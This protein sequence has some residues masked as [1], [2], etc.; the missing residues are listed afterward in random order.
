MSDVLIWVS[1][2]ADA[3]IPAGHMP[4]LE[5]AWTYVIRGELHSALERI[6]ELRMRSDLTPYESDHLTA[7]RLLILALA[8]RAAGHGEARKVLADAD[9]SAAA[10]EA[11]AMAVLSTERW[12]AGEMSSALALNR[13]AV[14]SAASL[15]PVWRVYVQYLMAKKLCEMKIPGKALALARE[16]DSLI[17]EFGMHA[18]QALP[19]AIHANIHLASGDFEGAV[20]LAETVERISHQRVTTIGMRL[21]L[22]VS[23][24]AHLR[25]GNLE[26]AAS[27]LAFLGEQSTVVGLPDSATRSALAAA[28]LA[29][30][31]EGP[32]AGARRVRE[33]WA[34]LHPA[35]PCL[36]EDPSRPAWLVRLALD[37]RDIPLAER[38][39]VSVEALSSRNPGIMLL[40][41]VSSC[42]RAVLEDDRRRL[43]ELLEIC[44]DPQ[45]RAWIAADLRR[46]GWEPPSCAVQTGAT[47]PASDRAAPAV[48]RGRTPLTDREHA[49]A[50]AVS[51]GMTSRQAARH[52]DITEHTVNFH[53][54]KIYRK[55][56]I[57][58]RSELSWIMATRV[59]D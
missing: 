4:L 15:S 49:V 39:T 20:R 12:Y 9:G 44:G 53:L 19:L 41:N 14:E 33:C 30:V 45:L 6:A 55:W 58:N 2:G 22:S 8:D 46:S 5:R 34:H 54:R 43:A 31:T 18:L 42:A 37:A 7:L 1:L 52:L 59:T 25:L 48:E 17:G 47:E 35:A 10:S 21:A 51:Q 36:L 32:E 26:Q 13:R 50:V 57:A 24:T 56:G 23:A 29:A 40:D 28:E 27:R 38:I 16:M 3:T 11:I